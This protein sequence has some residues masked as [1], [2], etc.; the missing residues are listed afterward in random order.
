[1]PFGTKEPHR[2]YLDR[3]AEIIGKE[4]SWQRPSY[5]KKTAR[6][7]DLSQLTRRKVITGK[8]I[9]I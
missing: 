5:P 1:M 9:K 8:N 2:D 6:A 3:F 4:T 7:D